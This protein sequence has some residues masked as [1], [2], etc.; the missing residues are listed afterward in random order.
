M[1]ARGTVLLGFGTSRTVPVVPIKGEM[2][3]ENKKLIIIEGLPGSGKSTTAEL[4]RDILQ[5]NQIST[6]LFLEGNL[7]HPADYQTVSYFSAEEFASLIEQYVNYRNLLIKHA[8]AKNAGFIIPR[9][10]LRQDLGEVKLPEA[11]QKQLWK[12]DI[13]ELPM[14]KHIEL[15]TAKWQKFCEQAMKGEDTYIFECC[16][17]QNP[18]TIGMIK[19]GASDELVIEYVSRLADIIQPLNPTLIYVEQNDLRKSFEKAVQERPKEWSTGFIDYYNNQ[20]YGK[21]H[22]AEGQE[23]TLAVLEARSVLESKIFDALNIQKFKVDNSA[24]DFNGHK[25]R[26]IEKLKL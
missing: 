13:Y 11:L 19:Y 14:E 4:T 20:G 17:I 24:F 25:Q 7:D 23:G 8:E 10:K 2:V 5:E 21:E 15:I 18:V 12:H 16:F 9:F 26:I 6:Q 1:G 22:G 3:M